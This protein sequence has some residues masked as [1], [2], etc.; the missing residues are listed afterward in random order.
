[1]IKVAMLSRWHVHANDYAREANANKDIEIVAV[2]DEDAKRGQDWA[3]ELG[4]D[5]ES[6]LDALLAREDIDGVIVD[7]PTNLHEKVIIAAAQAG[8][9]IFTEK[10]LAITDEGVQDILNAVKDNKVSL[11]L[12]LP[13]LNDPSYLY[14][15]KALDDGLLGELTS[16]RCR[17]EHGG[18]VPTDSSPNGW[19]PEHF[20]NADQCGG[21]A[22]I[23]L[24]AHPIYLTNRLAGDVESVL[25][26]MGYFIGREVDD[27][28]TVITRHK[29]GAM[30]VIEAGF[31]ANG[32][33]FILELHGTKG[34]ILVE[35][36]DLKIR[37]SELG[38]GNWQTP[39]L[40]EQESS[41]MQQW[42]NEILHKQEP[43]ITQKDMVELTR[44]NVAAKKSAEEGK[45]VSLG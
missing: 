38:D 18:G 7:T 14:A 12:S 36:R 43:R 31:V 41:A 35:E 9:H 40:P 29:S 2:W 22:L 4:A 28:T 25:C 20:Y 21:G 5:F 37:S 33:P 10:V 15:Q 6:D 17:L 16:I 13:R 24:G 30:G 45:R 19:L 26:E 44:I 8:K 27:H 11:M 23:D 3:E 39:E 1:M 34:S 32:S 42:V